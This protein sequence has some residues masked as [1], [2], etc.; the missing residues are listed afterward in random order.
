M[1]SLDDKKWNLFQRRIWLFRYIPF[2][3]VVF[4]SGSLATGRMHENSDF[5]VLVLARQGRIFTTRAA[6]IIA[7]GFFGWRR[8]KGESGVA[9]KDKI[10]LNHFATP[11]AYCLAPPHNAYWR[12]LYAS[13]VPVCGDP[14][15][16]Q[17]FYDANQDWMGMRRIYRDDSRHLYKKSSTAKT[18]LEKIAGGKLGALCEDALKK[19]QMRRINGGVE[20]QAGFKPRIIANDAE[21]EFHPDTARIEA[22]LGRLQAD[23]KTP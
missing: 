14:R 20:S 11:A 3:D 17:E 23:K 7:F 4:A 21:L 18:V 9:A 22:Y 13:L 19:I 10:C 6:C 15:T 1:E 5:D 12:M 16:I 2:V 8:K